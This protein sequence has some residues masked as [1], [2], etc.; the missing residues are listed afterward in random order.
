MVEGRLS[1]HIILEQSCKLRLQ[2]QGGSESKVCK[3]GK[4]QCINGQDVPET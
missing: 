2:A 4:H 3:G 1:A